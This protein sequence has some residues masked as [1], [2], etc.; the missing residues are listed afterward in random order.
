MSNIDLSG[1]DN[2]INKLNNISKNKQ[3]I[4]SIIVETISDMA[5]N[6]LNDEY[7][8]INMLDYNIDEDEDGIPQCDIVDIKYNKK[9][10][11][12][13]HSKIAYIEFGTGT[14][15]LKS[16][17]PID[18]LISNNVPYTGSW[19]YNYESGKKRVINGRL[20]WFVPKNVDGNYIIDIQKITK[21]GI[22]H[23]YFSQGFPAGMQMFNL[24]LKIKLDLISGGEYYNAIK[25][26]L[27]EVI[28]ND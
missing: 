26:R 7:E 2:F 13:R 18:K 11:V 9:S 10:L 16:N 23:S 27:N 3:K 20:G 19:V 4:E 5:Q 8:N 24:C 21:R 12:A 6:D 28:R 22:K 15:G 1:L 14:L 17:Y 25:E